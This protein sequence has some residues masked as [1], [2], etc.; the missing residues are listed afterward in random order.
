MDFDLLPEW[1]VSFNLNHLRFDTTEVLE[2]SRNQGGID[3]E[4]GWDVSVASIYRPFMTQNVI[5]RFSAAALL[6]GEGYEQ[7][8]GDD[9]Q[10]SILANLV[11][12]Y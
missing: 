4:I 1:R 6:P 5:F 10:Y 7:M 9:T 2:A 11:L 8:Y 3:E 12:A